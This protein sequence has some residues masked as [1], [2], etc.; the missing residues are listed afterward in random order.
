MQRSTT[1]RRLH[2]LRQVPYEGLG[3]I[4]EWAEA[5]AVE[6]SETRPYLGEAYPD[7]AD[8]QWLVVL[9]GPM[10]ASDEESVPWLRAE[11]EFLRAA[12]DHGTQVLG[13]CLGAQMLAKVLGGRVSRH[14]HAEIGWHQLELLPEGDWL[15]PFVVADTA[16][17]QWHFDSFTL[18]PGGVQLARTEGCEQQAFLWGSNVL[19]L[20][21]H[22]EFTMAEAERVAA[23]DGEPVA[24]PF[25]QRLDE[26]LDPRRF[27]MLRRASFE[28]L[29]RYSDAAFPGC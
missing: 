24:G 20:Q 12:I 17:L 3:F 11:M 25:S 27:E 16:V 4:G 2:Y 7:L 10:G 21:F 13:I 15:T 22:P 18:P 5:R 9:G 19:G 23:R 8:L 1:L 26:I 6:V 28:F 14:P 29:D